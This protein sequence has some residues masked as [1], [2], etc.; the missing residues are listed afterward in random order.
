VYTSPST[1]LVA[2]NTKLERDLYSCSQDDQANVVAY[3]SKMFAVPRSELPDFRTKEVTAEEMRRRGKEARERRAAAEASGASD[4]TEEIKEIKL[5]DGQLP[6]A[7]MPGDHSVEITQEPK[8]GEALIGFARIYS[9]AIRK[10]ATVYCVSPKYN[11]ALSPDHPSN[12]KHISSVEIA[13][14]YMMMGRELVPVDVVP[15]G[16]IFAIAGLEGKVLR[17]ATLCAP[18]ANGV[19]EEDVVGQL[20]DC[21]VN[22]A[23]VA[24]QVAP[25][26]RVALEPENPGECLVVEGTAERL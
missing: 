20:K 4:A 17:N 22:L 18:N 25:I 12:A 5:V 14:L 24:M 7:A 16:N 10:G 23:G 1:G 6:D 3:V 19:S 11:T 9:G 26:V 21:L 13:N 8:S 2:P 15:A